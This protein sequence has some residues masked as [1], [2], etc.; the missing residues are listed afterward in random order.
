M[1]SQLKRKKD[2][3]TELEIRDRFISRI[4]SLTHRSH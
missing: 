3:K 4:I 1:N 2:N